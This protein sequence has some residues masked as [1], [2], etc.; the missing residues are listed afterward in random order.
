[1]V[2]VGRHEGGKRVFVGRLNIDS[3]VGQI[4]LHRVERN[5]PGIRGIAVGSILRQEGPERRVGFVCA[6]RDT[7][8]KQ[9]DYRILYSVTVR[10]LPTNFGRHAGDSGGRRQG[11]TEVHGHQGAGKVTAALETVAIGVQLREGKLAVGNLNVA[12]VAPEGAGTG[13]ATKRFFAE[14]AGIQRALGDLCGGGEGG[15]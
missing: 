9:P 15:E 6:D 13:Q 5:A 12:S 7:A 10:G 8:D 11:K 4:D 3:E 2:Y 1:M 14:D